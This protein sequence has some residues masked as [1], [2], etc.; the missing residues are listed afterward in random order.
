VNKFGLATGKQFK[1]SASTWS[2]ITYFAKGLIAI[3]KANKDFAI[4]DAKG[5]TSLN[6]FLRHFP[7][8]CAI[9]AMTKWYMMWNCRNF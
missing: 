8:K 9:W 7:T 3:A 6:L 5:G 2:Y 1:A 4:H